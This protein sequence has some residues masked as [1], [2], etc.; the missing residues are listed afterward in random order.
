MS[1]TSQNKIEVHHEP[2]FRKSVFYCG[3]RI[4]EMPTQHIR[5]AIA[6]SKRQLESEVVKLGVRSSTG[7]S[8]PNKAVSSVKTLIGNL[9]KELMKRNEAI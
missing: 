1:Q 3:Q 6:Q 4:E 8:Y 5:N 9:E 2:L 7:M